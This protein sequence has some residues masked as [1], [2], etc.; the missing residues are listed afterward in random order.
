M[1]IDK[2]LKKEYGDI[3]FSADFIINRPTKIISFSPRLDVGLSGGIPT[4]SWVNIAGPPKS[5]KSS[6][7]LS[8]AANAQQ[9]GMMVYYFDVEC[10]LKKM[11]LVGTPNLDISP[12]KFQIISSSEEKILTAEDITNIASK[13][14]KSQKDVFLIIDSY[15]ALCSS[16]EYVDDITGQTRSLGPKILASFTRQMASVVPIQGSIVILIGHI[17]A[18][19]GYGPSTTTLDGG[20]KIQYQADVRMRVKSF[21]LIKEE[22]EIVGQIVKWHVITS[23]LGPPV[24]EVE[25][26]IRFG[27]GID[28]VFEYMMLALDIGVISKAGAWLEFDGEKVQGQA[29]MYQYLIDNPD[30]LAKIK[31]EIKKML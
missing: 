5:G 6:S 16:K 22:N 15:S 2:E 4:G 1:T 13:I 27:K 23:A 18:N 25:S 7:V 8:L 12:E 20:I 10:R 14:L 9:Q 17:I 21:E 11:N 24:A 28:S 19:T 3:L 31:E 30:K 26:Y 29:K